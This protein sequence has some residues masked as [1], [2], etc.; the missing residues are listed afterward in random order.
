M[1][2]AIFLS[3]VSAHPGVMLEKDSRV[4]PEVPLT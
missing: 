1:D 4:I 3:S 2:G